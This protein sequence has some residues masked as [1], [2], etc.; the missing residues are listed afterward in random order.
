MKYWPGVPI[1]APSGLRTHI[2]H[3]PSTAANTKAPKA[4][5]KCARQ[6]RSALRTGGP[7]VRPGFELILGHH[8]DVGIHLAVA[9]AAIL[10]TRHQQIPGAGENGVH[11][12]Y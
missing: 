1:W 10:V 7:P 6:R 9:E 12:R 11:L 4:T 3:V 2:C 5:H 8:L